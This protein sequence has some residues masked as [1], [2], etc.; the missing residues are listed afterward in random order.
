MRSDSQNQRG[1]RPAFLRLLTTR[2][3][4][5][6]SL[7]DS[8]GRRETIRPGGQNS[9]TAR[10]KL[11]FGKN[12]YALLSA[13]LLIDVPSNAQTVDSLSW[14][15]GRRRD[16]TS[17]S[18]EA[19]TTNANVFQSQPLCR[20][21]CAVRGEGFSM[22]CRTRLTGSPTGLHARTSPGSIQP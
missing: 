18:S 14:S 2:S 22:N 7:Q 8:I 6:Q 9:S 4:V 17:T 11:T 21:T 15:S 12:V 3:G 5:P 16:P 1:S 10:E 13:S 20:Q 19:F